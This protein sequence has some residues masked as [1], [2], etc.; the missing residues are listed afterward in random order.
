MARSSRSRKRKSTKTGGA[1]P[2]SQFAIPQATQVASAEAA[3]VS[4]PTNSETSGEID[5]VAIE[6]SVSERIEQLQNQ[7]AELSETRGVETK[8]QANRYMQ[9]AD[10]LDASCTTLRESVAD[11]REEQEKLAEDRRSLE[12]LHAPQAHREAT[13]SREEG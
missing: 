11:L 5:S 12:A 7:I 8:A 6:I 10:Q 4:D 3:V 9:T 2:K 1:A 13:N